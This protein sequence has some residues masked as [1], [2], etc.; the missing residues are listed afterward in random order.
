M[1]AAI[2]Q[3]TDSLRHRGPDKGANW[4][5]VDNGVALGHRRLAVV[6]LTEAGSQPMVSQSG[7]YVMVFNGEIYNHL[8]LRAEATRKS[9]QIQWRGTCDSETLLECIALWGVAETLER[10][11]G[12]FA[13]ALW[14]RET[15][16]LTLIRDRFGEKPLYYGTLGGL[17]VFASELR[18]FRKISDT[19]IDIDETALGLYLQYGYVPE[20]FSILVGISKLEP[21]CVL[22]VS[23]AQLRSATVPT[24]LPFW[25]AADVA[26]KAAENQLDTSDHKDKANQLEALLNQSVK[27]Q[28]VA[29]VPLGAFLSGGIDSSTVVGIMQANSVDTVRT[30]SIGFEQADFNEAHFAKE[31]AQHLGTE[32]TELYVTNQELLDVVPQ[33]PKIWDEPFSDSSQIPTFLVSQLARRDVTVALSG[34]GGDELFGGYTR[35]GF[36][37]QIWEKVERIPR[38]LRDAVAKSITSLSPHS[39]DLL[40]KPLMNLIPSRF[41]FAQLGDKLHLAAGPL[42]A[43]SG[44]DAHV[45]MVQMQSALK[46]MGKFAEPDPLREKWPGLGDLLENMMVLD[47][48]TYLPGDVLAKVDR[49]AMALSLETRAPFLDHRI[50]EFSRQLPMGFKVNKG[51]GKWLLRQVL[52][53]YVPRELVNRPKMGFGVPVGKWLA[54]PLRDWASELLDPEL[55]R[56]SGIR[57]PETVATMWSDQ[58]NGRRN[59]SKQI[60]AIVCFVEWRNTANS[61]S[62][63]EKRFP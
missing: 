4:W 35:Y 19:S 39:W 24:P 37:Q 23:P 34:D 25:S 21:G 50:Y 28:M 26:R 52:D 2:Q 3:M 53:R 47:A 40:S 55:L 20:P 7:R 29:D 61:Q 14:D 45:A 22:N 33:I 60:W 12:M 32:H 31:V 54:G 27:Q 56:D 59:W 46:L 43:K 1:E 62:C 16:S 57:H 15:R 58:L 17:F 6:D 49:A 30:Y 44:Q 13:V 63:E 10:C 48:I 18:A 9:P 5:D 51:E 41:R 38:P 11:V 36:T 42:A 8:D